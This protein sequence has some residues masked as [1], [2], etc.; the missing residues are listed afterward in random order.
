MEIFLES[1]ETNN[2]EVAKE[3]LQ[4]NRELRQQYFGLTDKTF[5]R[6]CLHWALHYNDIGMVK[7]LLTFKE[8]DVNALDNSGETI[9]MAALKYVPQRSS[10]G[11]M[12]E[13]C[14]KEPVIEM[15]KLLLEVN[16]D[17]IN[18]CSSIKQQSPLQ[19]AM[20]GQSLDVIKLLIQ[21]G[22]DVNHKSIG[23]SVLHE[24]AEHLRMDVIR[25]LLDETH[26]DPLVA[27]KHGL[28][29]CYVFVNKVITKGLIDRETMD[30]CQL[31]LLNTYKSPV[32]SVTVH[33]ILLDCFASSYLASRES[34]FVLF[35]EIIQLITGNHPQKHLVDKIFTANIEC[36]LSLG[37]ILLF[38]NIG[39]NISDSNICPTL[40]SEY[41]E[42]LDQLET[43]CLD[44]LFRLFTT[45]DLLATEYAD[46][47]KKMGFVLD[48]HKYLNTFFSY[49]SP[50]TPVE[51]IYNFFNMIFSRGHV[52]SISAVVGNQ[53]MAAL[54]LMNNF[55]HAFVPLSNLTQV[56]LEVWLATSPDG[57]NDNKRVYSFNESQHWAPDFN[58]LSTKPMEKP[59]VVSLMN[60]SRMAVRKC[61]F[62]NN[63][64]Y[65]ALK[66]LRSLY[67]PKIISQYLCYNFQNFKL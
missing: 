22:S 34:G 2:F 36:D 29:P 10:N 61:V 11:I 51:T 65:E 59:E 57:S 50:D 33:L 67:L 60:L 39:Q 28:P 46:E 41:N 58:R 63:N 6:N 66:V 9:F 19:V 45:D 38:E 53:N 12:M 24:A 56:P 40:I 21:L 64:H 49:L 3:M 44:E 32:E 26:C 42:L 1:C 54:C 47:L 16:S 27:D 23:S 43:F 48:Q 7:H 13:F 20:Q 52:I 31:F 14:P 5:G 17:F 25:Y 30:F 18:W 35:H 55:W 62:E 8:L 37:A 15:I 4:N